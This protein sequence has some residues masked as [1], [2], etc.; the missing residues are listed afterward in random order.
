MVQSTKPAETRSDWTRPNSPYSP[1]PDG[2]PTQFY[3]NHWGGDV[4][5]DVCKFVLNQAEIV[6]SISGVSI[7]RSLLTINQLFFV[8]ESLLFCKANSLEW[9][10]IFGISDQYEKTYRQKLNKDKTSIFFSINVLHHMLKA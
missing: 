6:G 5:N 2:F 10:R 9:S 7:G 8:D 4:G 1:R 3:Q